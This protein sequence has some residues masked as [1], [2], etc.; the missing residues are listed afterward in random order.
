MRSLDL[1][2]LK[3]SLDLLERSLDLDLLELRSLDL[4]LS[5]GFLISFPL[6][7]S[8]I[9][10]TLRSSP[11]PSLAGLLPCSGTTSKSKNKSP[12]SKI[13]FFLG[14]AWAELASVSFGNILGIF[15]LG[16]SS[17][18]RLSFL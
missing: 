9:S 5:L 3:P 11:P 17:S 4:N 12:I 18:I 13:I 16:F 8:L 14:S 7:V 1:D 15:L 2:L 10:T 6:S